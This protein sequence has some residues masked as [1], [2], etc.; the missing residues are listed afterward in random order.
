MGGASGRIQLQLLIMSTSV[1]STF[2]VSFVNFEV[3][4]RLDSQATSYNISTYADIP[5]GT[6][7]PTFHGH[8]LLLLYSR[9]RSYKVLESS[10]E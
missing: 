7:L 3:R 9:Y 2:E 4:L 1:V 8:H 6:N 10:A 5:A